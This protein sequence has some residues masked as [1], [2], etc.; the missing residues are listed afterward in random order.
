MGR[1][2]G[3]DGAERPAKEGEKG[4]QRN[5]LGRREEAHNG[6]ARV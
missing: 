2:W 6:E 4:T 3:L 5:E 1:E